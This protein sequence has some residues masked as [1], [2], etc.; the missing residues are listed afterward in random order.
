MSKLNV[1]EVVMVDACDKTRPGKMLVLDSAYTTDLGV[2][3][4]PIRPD[5]LD[6][7]VTDEEEIE[8]MATAR[9]NREQ[10]RWIG[11]RLLAF[12]NGEPT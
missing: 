10:A 9:I 5:E 3:L 4:V 12:A 1:K 8:G 7:Q 2:L 6:L 11:E